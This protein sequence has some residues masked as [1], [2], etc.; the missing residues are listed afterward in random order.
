[1]LLLRLH[2]RAQAQSPWGSVR[3]IT[4]HEARAFSYEQITGAGKVTVEEGFE[5]VKVP[6]TV[7]F[8]EVPDL[9]GTVLLQRI[10]EIAD[11]VAKQTSQQGYRKLDQIT[12][13][14]GTAIDAGGGPFT[15]ELFLQSEEVREM[16]FDP[17]T[18]K[19]EGI[20][21][22]H[23][24]TAEYMHGLWKEWEL[25]PAFM[26]RARDIRAKKYEEW[27]DRESRRKLVD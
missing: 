23:P 3:Q 15:Q 4:Q 10:D 5:E 19:P 26:R 7:R 20:Y 18:G 8:E 21:V 6:V 11:E 22:A 1:M 12:R 9:V 16:D 24:K 2:L 14:A 25:D 13:Q 17:K 27:R